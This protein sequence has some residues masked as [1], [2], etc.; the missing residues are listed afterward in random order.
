MGG[1]P[2]LSIHLENLGCRRLGASQVPGPMEKGVSG[3]HAPLLTRL[4]SSS[5]CPSGGSRQPTF[6]SASLWSSTPALELCCPNRTLWIC[7]VSSG[8]WWGLG[9]GRE[10]ADKAVQFSAL[11]SPKSKFQEVGMTP[12]LILYPYKQTCEVGSSVP[13]LQRGKP[14]LRAIKDLPKIT[15]QDR[16]QGLQSQRFKPGTESTPSQSQLATG[17]TF[18]HSPLFHIRH[19]TCPGPRS[20]P[21]QR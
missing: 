13:I 19:V 8:E 4:W 5:S 12:T 21:Y 18:V 10:A 15:N 3:A 14:R 20:S 6:S 16:R 7:R 2:D 1:F 11:S 17:V 9:W